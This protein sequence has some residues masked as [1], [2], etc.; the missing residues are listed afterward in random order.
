MATTTLAIGGLRLT[1]VLSVDTAI[2]PTASGRSA[3]EVRGVAWSEPL[4]AEGGKVRVAAC[5]NHAKEEL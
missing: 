4:W 3:E 2:G 5:A 1:R